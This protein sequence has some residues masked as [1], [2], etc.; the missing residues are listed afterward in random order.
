MERPGAGPGPCFGHFHSSWRRAG[1]R[2]V[3]V[4]P[5]LLPPRRLAI[6]IGNT[7]YL[8]KIPVTHPVEPCFSRISAS[9][10]FLTA[11]LARPIP[12]RA[13]LK[14]CPRRARGSGTP[15]DRGAAGGPAPAPRGH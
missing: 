9:P 6:S 13:P 1:F 11:E 14:T 10:A 12:A 2:E 4:R 8:V 5:Y 15:G 7:G 3:R